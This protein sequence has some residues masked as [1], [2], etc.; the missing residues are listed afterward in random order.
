M[1]EAI[2]CPACS[3][4]MSQQDFANIIADLCV[5]GCRGIWFDRGELQ[6]LDHKLKGMN[7]AL[8]E[9]LAEP[10][11]NESRG[12]ID[13]PRCEQQMDQLE[14]VVQPEVTVD[15]CAACGGIFLDAGELAAIRDRPLTPKELA[16]GRI[17]RRHRA[18]RYQREQEAIAAADMILIVCNAV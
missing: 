17:R 5:S 7:P 11:R 1:T 4:P 12:L 15:T 10:G 18:A 13:C 8:R 6:K 2:H 16:R 14:Y 9:A 3:V